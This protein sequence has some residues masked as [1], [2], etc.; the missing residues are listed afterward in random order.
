MVAGI[1]ISAVSSGD[2]PV[3]CFSW[4][5]FRNAAYGFKVGEGAKIVARKH[6]EMFVRPVVSKRFEVVF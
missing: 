3:A 1:I 2:L 4:D 6:K 5:A